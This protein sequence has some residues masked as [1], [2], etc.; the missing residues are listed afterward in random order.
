MFTFG[1]SPKTLTITLSNI[2]DR[3]GK[4]WARG[5][6][7]SS[8][9]CC[10]RNTAQSIV[11]CD[12]GGWQHHPLVH[13]QPVHPTAI[14]SYLIQVKRKHISFKLGGK[15]ERGEP[16]GT[17]LRTPDWRSVK[18]SPD[19]KMFTIY[20]GFHLIFKYGQKFVLLE[21][22]SPLMMESKRRTK[23]SFPFLLFLL[24][25]ITT[26]PH[27]SYLQSLSCPIQTP[28]WYPN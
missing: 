16:L 22:D 17:M 28:V 8:C 3:S 1:K 23:F 20:T 2:V 26:P 10:F 9:C 25:H 18:S 6:C 11:S 27:K 13:V 21:I 14:I 19:T 5:G 7:P 15:V 4:I 24:F 12:P